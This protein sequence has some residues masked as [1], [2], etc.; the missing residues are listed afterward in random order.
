M[1]KLL[2]LVFSL[3]LIIFSALPVLADVVNAKW[4][5]N[6]NITNSGAD[7]TDVATVFSLNSTSMISQ[8]FANTTLT[9]VAILGNGADVPF[10]PGYANN[11]WAVFVNSIGTTST[12]NDNL[13]TKGATGGNIVYFPDTAGMSV[14]A[15]STLDISNNGN[16]TWDVFFN[17]ASTGYLVND[18]NKFTVIGNGDGTITAGGVLADYP[19]IASNTTGGDGAGTATSVPVTIPAGIVANDLLLAVV[20]ADRPAG[21]PTITTASGWTQLFQTA[22]VS[23]GTLGAWYKVS[24]GSETTTSFALSAASYYTF[25]CF[26]IQKGTYIGVPVAGTSATGTSAAPNPP[27]L[28]TGFG[29]VPTLF[30]ALNGNEGHD[31]TVAPADYAYLTNNKVTNSDLGTAERYYTSASDDP[32]VFT[33]SASDIWAA[34]TIAICGLSSFTSSA[35][36]ATE[37]IID[38][39]YLT[40]YISDSSFEDVAL[41]GWTKGGTGNLTRSNTEAKYGTYSCKLQSAGALLFAYQS[42]SGYA[43]FKGLNVASGCWVWTSSAAGIRMSLY[44]GVSSTSSSIATG[45]SSWQ[46]LTVIKA[47]S[48]SATEL[49]MRLIVDTVSATAYFDGAILSVASSLPNQYYNFNIISDGSYVGHAAIDG[50]AVVPASTGT[51]S[52]CTGNIMPYIYSIK[53]YKGGV[54]TGYWYWE[55]AATFTDHSDNGHTATP[56]FRTTSSNANVSAT[57]SSFE[58]VKPAEATSPVT[59]A[60]EVLTDLTAPPQMYIEGDYSHV[61]AADAVNEILAK[62][63][64]PFALWWFPFIFIG[65]GIFGMMI[66]GATKSQGGEGSLLTQCIVCDA[67]LFLLAIMGPIMLW[68]GILFWVP[69]TALILSRKHYGYG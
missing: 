8:G 1:K 26:R 33:L 50:A 32:G 5:F 38:V 16:Y 61:P 15:S 44:D 27:S 2:L 64:I 4:I 54:L 13:Y 19:T 45:S 43:S 6:I 28:T 59:P 22:Y 30:I 49:T 41:T 62:S 67:L 51:F 34:N 60:G 10:M 57:V 46:F 55:Y 48:G 37:Q 56:S 25:Q 69:A 58:P 68:P 23:I 63:D 66:F 42:Y 21:S 17:P 9:D 29:S 35:L 7:T 65:I 31:T 40:N 3:Y 11:P 47:V 14:V 12:I 53:V 52:W 24:N 36:S 20:N 18:P 39:S